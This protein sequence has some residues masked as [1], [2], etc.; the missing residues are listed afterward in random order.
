MTAAGPDFIII[1]AGKSGT[2][3]LYKYLIQHPR[4][5]PA[6]TKQVD[7]FHRWFDRGTGWYLEQFPTDRAEG[8]V[9]GEA[10][11]YYMFHPHVPRRIRAF[12]PEIKLVAVLRNPVDRTYSHYQHQV[13]GR[14]ETLSFEEAL[15][16]EEQRLA[17]EVPKLMED[18]TY[19]SK[20]H[21][22]LSYKARSRYA[23]QLEAWFSLF[24]REQ[25]LI[26]HSEALFA[27]PAS[28]LDQV[29]SF[30]GVSPVRLDSYNR[31]MAGSYWRPMSGATRRTLIDYFRPYNQRLY[32]LLDVTYPWD[33]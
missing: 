6:A 23:D 11:P 2:T 9:T 14:Y 3:S 25:T 5:A 29:A 19:Y 18:E 13:R 32:E 16:A 7:F 4:V 30:L 27:E 33:V 28:V 15:T 22:R 26:L 24:P 10:S 8:V 17:S 20:V 1:G 12:R 31:Y 21:R